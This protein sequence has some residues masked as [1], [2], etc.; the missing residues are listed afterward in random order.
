MF[1]FFKKWVQ[2]WKK[3]PTQLLEEKILALRRMGINAV[4]IRSTNTPAESFDQFLNF[5][6][7]SK[8]SGLDWA[9]YKVC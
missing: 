1:G 5:I 6:S 2:S 4:I 3:S 8:N 7:Q 9:W